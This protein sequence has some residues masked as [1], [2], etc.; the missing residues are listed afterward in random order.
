MIS[1]LENKAKE[2]ATF[3][4]KGQKRKYTDEPYINHPRNVAILVKSVPHT[5]EMVAAAWLHDVLEDTN[6][7]YEII[8]RHL[9]EDVA[10]IVSMLTDVSS[11]N[12]GNRKIRKEIDRLHI[13]KASPEAKTIKLADLIDNTKSIVKYDKDFSFVYLDEVRLLIEVLEEGDVFLYDE[14]KKILDN[15]LYLLSK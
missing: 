9:G 11:Y 8:F 13:S 4:H 7:T 2:F 1:L 10:K 12:D 6:A 5:D 15:N 14:L 3:Y